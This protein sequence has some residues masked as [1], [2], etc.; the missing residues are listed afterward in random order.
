MQV[1]ADVNTENS[2][3]KFIISYLNSL[4]WLCFRIWNCSIFR[5]DYSE[6][7]INGEHSQ[8]DLQQHFIRKHIK[9]S[10]MN[11]TWRVKERAQPSICS[12]TVGLSNQVR[13][14]Q[15]CYQ[16]FI[17]RLFWTLKL[18]IMDCLPL[19]LRDLI[20]ESNKLVQ[21]RV[22]NDNVGNRKI[23]VEPK[24]GTQTRMQN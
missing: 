19:Q 21:L 3:Y 15:F 11:A 8:Q 12:S 14:G 24:K 20:Q 1:F 6:D 9:T 5:K 10:A 16:G 23:L 22:A 2:Q 4:G 7:L 17:F 18:W 13:T